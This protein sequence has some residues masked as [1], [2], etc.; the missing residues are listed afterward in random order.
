[1]VVLQFPRFQSH[2]SM[3]QK[4]VDMH[5]QVPGINTITKYLELE[6]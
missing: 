5:Y 4:F 1:M 2:M 3:V 6:C